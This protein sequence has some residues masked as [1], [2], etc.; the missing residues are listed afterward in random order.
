[1]KTFKFCTMPARGAV[2]ANRLRTSCETDK[3]SRTICNFLTH[4]EQTGRNLLLKFLGEF[5]DLN[6]HF[7][8]RTFRFRDIRHS[9][10]NVALKPGP[11]A[12]HRI[13]TRHRYKVFSGK[14]TQ[15][16]EFLVDIRLSDFSV[17][18]LLNAN[19]VNFRMQLHNT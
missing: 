3:R 19:A 7:R 1:M 15:A 16:N 10:P 17:A 4:I 13:Y 5:L 2:I 11:L 18:F 14:L 12:L 9:A 6:I 8:N